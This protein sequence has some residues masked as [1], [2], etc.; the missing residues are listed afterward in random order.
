MSQ[1]NPPNLPKSVGFW[2]LLLALISMGIAMR[3][4]HF[5]DVV[6]RGPDERVYTYFAS[7][8]ANGGLSAVPA[9]FAGYEANVSSRIYPGPGRFGHLPLFATVMKLSGD[10]T[11]RA[12]ATL[13]LVCS[14]LSLFLCAWMALRFF[15][16]AVAL[17]AVTF[18]ASSVGELGMSRRAW[19]DATFGFAC[20]LLVYLASEITVRPG[21]F[22]WYGLFFSM[23]VFCL[24]TKEN[25]VIPYGL[26]GLWLFAILL[27]QEH[28]WRAAA[29]FAWG[30][31]MSVVCAL[32]IL[33]ALAGS[34][35]L[36]FS[37]LDH[38]LW[39]QT[40]DPS[41]W[42]FRCC[43]GPWYQFSYLLWIVGPVAT[44]AA[45]F[46]LVATMAPRV[47]LDKREAPDWQVARLC[48]LITTGVWAFASFYPNIQ[49]LRMFSPADG[50]FSLLAGLGVWHLI[51]I[52]RV[53]LPFRVSHAVAV[54]MIAATG[55]GAARDYA[56]FRSVVV[57]SDM[58][59]LPVTWIRQIMH[60]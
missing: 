40:A 59:E 22:R 26:C 55:L 2:I 54:M 36:A 42:T 11:A 16:P 25:A 9:L 60:R 7:R 58:Q 27:V 17:L 24:I 34:A 46:G 39:H 20:F 15:S 12:G 35:R 3:L 51:S 5:K 32:G 13:S 31:L 29:V 56:V 37:V 4:A 10:Q 30:G 18:L 23:G 47:N 53:R 28:S 21:A 43:S 48:V 1:S 52:A 50:T 45:V 44:A 6:S 14:I 49:N 57:A 33:C 19:Q 8:I 38:A 41:N